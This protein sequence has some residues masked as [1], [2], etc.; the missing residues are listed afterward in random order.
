MGLGSYCTIE[1]STAALA[2]KPIRQ[3]LIWVERSGPLPFLCSQ[4]ARKVGLTWQQLPR[5]TPLRPNASSPRSPGCASGAQ[6]PPL[7]VG[8][9]AVRSPPLPVRRPAVRSPPWHHLTPALSTR[10]EG[11]GEASTAAGAPRPSGAHARA[12]S[13]F[14]T[15][16]QP[17][18]QA[19][20]KPP[21]LSLALSSEQLDLTL[22]VSC[23]PEWLH[24]WLVAQLQILLA[25]Y[26]AQLQHDSPADLLR[27]YPALDP[28][29]DRLS[30]LRAELLSALLIGLA[31]ATA[32]LDRVSRPTRNRALV[33][34][35]E[36][37]ASMAG[38]LARRRDAE[39][40]DRESYRALV[41]IRR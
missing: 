11:R 30:E 9:P 26:R 7:P 38:Q 2:A 19:Q 37:V 3:R 40:L 17:P 34:Q 16:P 14:T 20:Q 13:L 31:T 8:K 35:A 23:L 25:H 36:R 4:T 6:S 27:A 22:L 28:R 5:P 21:R 32:P 18:P 41:G 33:A 1:T 39:P 12:A 10:G 15:P 24:Y 29:Q